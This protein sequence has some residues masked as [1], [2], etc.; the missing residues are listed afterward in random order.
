M[1]ATVYYVSWAKTT[2]D[3]RADALAGD[4][5]AGDKFIRAVWVDVPDNACLGDRLLACEFMFRM[6]SSP[7]RP[8]K[9]RSMSVGDVV[10]LDGGESGTF[11]CDSAGFRLV[12]G[13]EP[14]P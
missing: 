7:S 8:E 1:K 13:W 12:E 5:L 6:L 2:S 3:E 4:L 14:P 10:V 11:L 9:L